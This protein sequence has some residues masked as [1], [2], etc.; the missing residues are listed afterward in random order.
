M[1][2]F[3]VHLFGG[4]T[5]AVVLA[6]REGIGIGSGLG[7]DHGRTSPH[8][9]HGFAREPRR[10]GSTRAFSDRRIVVFGVVFRRSGRAV[11]SLWCGESDRV[12]TRVRCP[13]SISS[14]EGLCM[15]R[16]F[17][18][19]FLWAILIGL[20]Q[21]L[22]LP[23]LYSDKVALAYSREL[24]GLVFLLI[25]LA[26]FRC[27]R[28]LLALTSVSWLV[29]VAF[30]WVRG[31][32]ILAMKQS[33]LLYDAYFLAG[34]L[35]ILLRDLMGFKA[36]LIFLAIGA[37]FLLI[38]V[39][40]HGL[41]RWILITAQDLG[42][43]AKLIGLMG[44]VAM[45]YG[46]ENKP[47]IRARN[48]LVD[49]WENGARSF[50]VYDEIKSGVQEGV[51]E[52]VE[53]VVLKDRP[54]VHV[55]VVESYGRA[56]LSKAIK[57]DFI[58]YREEMAQRFV[59]AGW[60][61]ATVLSEAPVMGGRS[62]L[63]DA[64]LL[65]GRTVKYESVYRHLTP[66]LKDIQSIPRFF[67]DRGYRTI[68]MRPKDKA[69]PGVELVNHFGFSDTVFHVDLA[70][71]GQN[72]GWVEIPDQYSLGH[73]RDVVLPTLDGEPEFVFAHLGSSHIPWDDLPPILDDWRRLNDTGERKLEKDKALT[74]KEI[75]FQLG[76][77]KRQGA[78]RLRRLRPT[79]ENIREYFQAVRYSLEVVARHVL[80]M[81][82][83]PD[84][85]F[86]MGDHQPPLYKKSN[87][88]T[89]PIHVLTRN[90]DA[91]D[92]FTARGFQ[93]GHLFPS[94]KERIFHEG[95]FSLLVG[96]L[97]DSQNL[98]PPEFRRRGYGVSKGGNTE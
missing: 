47:D 6:L 16:I 83:P 14:I 79:A 38:S 1:A 92:G 4:Y 11:G 12:H 96:A 48:S 78:V 98:N 30:E 70:Y 65:S 94:R 22:S 27:A 73:I 90:P 19:V 89:V 50:Q 32:G 28:F 35:Y 40:S 45:I 84:I 95:F 17:A 5:L 63:A 10:L 58:E 43:R 21:I 80:A 18:I 57:A 69:R 36:T 86:I 33:P 74:K 20:N 67:K 39:V 76:R 24:M 31:V 51:Y 23:R 60:S 75:K 9:G 34:H 8:V 82:D 68:L 66:R 49:A 77:F 59:D 72:F 85:V 25:V 52:D 87:D 81:S 88:F 56:V 44:I 7:C 61:M 2:S 93:R 29:I 55:Y 91:L 46:A 53:S 37:V 71:K 26:K 97:A 3:G 41:F 15:N 13:F 42:W 64:T 62:W 54:R